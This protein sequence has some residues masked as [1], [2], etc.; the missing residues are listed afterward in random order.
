MTD[1]GL[2]APRQDRSRK[3]LERIL[4]SGTALITE[5]SY[6]DVTIT[7]IAARAQTSVGGFYSRF[8]NKEALF[9]A[10]Q[11]RLEEE[12]QSAVTEAYRKNWEADDLQGLLHH[13]VL[14]NAELYKKYRGVYGKSFQV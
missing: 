1:N 6:D 11:K 7:E 4:E 13:M 14:K 8:S 3:T 9:N 12:T 2:L 10:L 5:Q